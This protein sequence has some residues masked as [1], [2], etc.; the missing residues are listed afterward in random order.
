V[1]SGRQSWAAV[2]PVKR[3]PLAKS[4]LDLAPDL[5]SQLALAMAADTVTACRT[6]TR[7]AEV[8]VVTDD[9]LA[10]VTMRQLGATVV[11]DEPDAGLNPALRHGADVA[12]G[13]TELGVVA[14][15]SDL[16]ALTAAALDDVLSAAGSAPMA[17][18]ADVAGTGTTL[19]VASSAATFAPSFGAGSWQRHRDAG[20]VDL[21][22]RADAR[23]R[24]DVDTLADLAEAAAL[25]CGRATAALL[26]QVL[27]GEHRAG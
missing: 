8:V 2:V 10:A 12:A 16:P 26:G 7:I 23:L 1:A 14:L 22:D 21:T 13:Q 27:G 6:A 17:V 3:L 18:V 5:R 15:S 19:V 20:A 25:G 4:R 9:E 11:A 24:R